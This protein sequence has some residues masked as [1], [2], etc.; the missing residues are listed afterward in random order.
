M[1]K[2]PNEIVRFF[3]LFRES[4][5]LLLLTQWSQKFKEILT[6]D[7][8]TPTI[9]D[10]ETQYQLLLRQFPLRIEATEKVC[11]PFEKVFLFYKTLFLASISTYSSIQSISANDISRDQ[12]ICCS[13]CE[14]C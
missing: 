11:V 3:F 14:I 5:Q 6:K 7:N 13:L 9:I 10:D 4:Y 1:R 12:R 8:Y 2:K